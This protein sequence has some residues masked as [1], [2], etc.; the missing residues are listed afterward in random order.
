MRPLRTALWP[1]AL[2]AGLGAFALILTSEHEETP[3]ITG[4][5]TLLVGWSFAF[6]GLVA[7]TRRPA[8]FFGALMVAAGL[9]WFVRAVVAAD[10]AFA[11]TVGQI[12][13]YLVFGI[14][15][16]LLLA[17]PRG[18][19]ESRLSRILVA[20]AYLEATVVQVVYLL[21]ERLRAPGC[22]GCPANKILLS[23]NPDVAEGILLA[24]RA[25]GMV[26]AVLVA[27]IYLKRWQV[28]TPTARRV[29]GPVLGTG[30]LATALTTTWLGA[31]TIHDDAGRY[32][33]WATMTGLALVPLA[34]LAGLLR[35]RLA[36]ANVGQLVVALGQ[37]ARPGELRDAI[38]KALGDPSVALAYWLPESE[39]WVRIDGRRLPSL[40]DAEQGHV[41]T[42]VE[43]HGERVAAIVH[44]AFLN[45]DPELLDAVVAAAG[46]AFENEQRLAALT[47]SEARMR[48][49]LNA[50]PDL[51]FRMSR[52][53]VY[54]AVKAERTGDLVVPP[55]QLIG[56]NARDILPR[57]IAG[58][59]LNCIEEALEQGAA[60]T[61]EFEYEL[62]L[63]GFPRFFEARIVPSGEDEVVMLVR[64]FTE[65]HNSEVERQRLQAE[66]RERLEELQASRARMVEAGDNERR[67]L[68]RNLHDGAQQRL[69]AL[70][71]SLRLA[72]AKLAEPDA[73]RAI[74]DGASEELGAALEE[75]R[76]LARGIHPAVLT[77]RGLGPALEALVGR[78]PLPVE[79][80]AQLEERLPEQVEAAAYYVV[81]ESLAN[82]AKYANASSARV[83]ISRR[84][85]AAIVEVAD[86]GV[87]GA[88]PARGSGLR[89]LVDRVEAL[90]GRL[91]VESGPGRGTHTRAEIPCE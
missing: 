52:E 34:F 5:L 46:L 31:S 51:M 90:E 67:R 2:L 44:D 43:R 16:H 45:E 27:W 66:L 70:S 41:A 56:R 71:L 72:Q 86:D 87:G 49:V 11:F 58:P 25:G 80:E 32:A 63:E 57:E 78:T 68:E 60:R 10:E 13:Q 33:F 15:V 76:E 17:Y 74:L 37:T 53:G 4:A 81:S 8:N 65:R 35:S 1:V 91:E 64:D 7:W 59:L 18:R 42:I 82:V 69:V 75:L 20:V 77:D 47:Q 29:L 48:G 61:V 14:L 6:S 88:D 19:L 73:A 83:S 9:A 26:I 22:T 39:T 89:G 84:N 40:A 21:F 24:S 79:V 50:L 36:L 30:L 28:A 23:E 38:A 85:G 55:D 54:L 62:E 12:L 3:V